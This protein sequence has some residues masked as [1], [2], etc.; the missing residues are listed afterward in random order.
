MILIRYYYL[1]S[2]IRLGGH[3]S[4]KYFYCKCFSPKTLFKEK[5]TLLFPSPSLVFLFFFFRILFIYF[6][7]SHY[8]ISNQLSPPNFFTLVATRQKFCTCIVWITDTQ[9]LRHIWITSFLRG[10]RMIVIQKPYEHE[11]NQFFM[12]K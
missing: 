6:L 8:L 3:L 1:V 10:L 4:L 2:L 11:D 9:V 12:V 7:W 5:E